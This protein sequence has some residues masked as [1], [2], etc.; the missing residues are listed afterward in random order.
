MRSYV[1]IH[2]ARMALGSKPHR[3]RHTN[4]VI[5]KKVVCCFSK[6]DFSRYLRCPANYAINV[7]SQTRSCSIFLARLIHLIDRKRRKQI[8]IF[9]LLIV[10]IYQKVLLSHKI[11]HQVLNKSSRGPYDMRGNAK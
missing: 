10:S 6:L 1:I 9:V 11:S 7:N 8:V 3:T 2:V 5:N 4:I